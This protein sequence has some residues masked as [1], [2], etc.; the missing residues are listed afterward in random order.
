[1][2]K[3][4]KLVVCMA[5]GLS[6]STSAMADLIDAKGT[7]EMSIKKNGDLVNARRLAR[8]SSE[9]DAILQALRL[10]MS[11]DGDN[12]SVQNA[13]G[14]LSK[15][16]TDN[17]KT[18]FTTEGDVLTAKTSLSVDSAQLYDLARSIKGLVS[19]TAMASSKIIFL[20][21]EYYGISTNIQPGQP[22]ETEISYSHDKSSASSESSAASSSSSSKNSEAVAA[23]A[24]SSMAAS[25]DSSVAGRARSSSA[26]T[27]NASVAAR[28]GD[29]SLSAASNSSAA[30]S[31][32]VSASASRKS[33][34]A[35]A[36]NSNFAAASSSSKAE[37]NSSS[38]AS[39]SNQKDIVNYSMKQKFPDTNNAK[40]S[41]DAAAL[42]T[43][44]LEQII[45]PYGLAYTPERDFRRDLKG[46]KLLISDIE[47]QRKFIEYTEK[48]SKQPF[49]AKYI[50]YG[51]S[52]MSAEG[53]TS[54]GDTVCSGM[55]KLQSFNVDS[56]EALISGTLGKRAQGSS[57]QECRTNLATAL[58][59]ELASTVG[60]TAAKEVQL[61][62]TQG[63]SFYV[64]LYSDKKIS[65]A[66]R[67]EF[68]KKLEAM[69]KIEEGNST[70]TSRAWVIQAASGFRTKLEDIVDDL[71][72]AN[73]EA[74][75][76]KMI[77]K[78]NRVVVCLEGNCPKDF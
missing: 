20:I 11:I 59:T 43:A 71:S 3:L 56:G 47:K 44:R 14:D 58:A 35:A 49:S 33:S 4:K 12:P 52:V 66:I 1:M 60:N 57:D 74:K 73:A 22:L 16:L 23:K 17:L 9:R 36:S 34:V 13:L 38:S 65:S 54:S 8:I 67:R 63:Q 69:G 31:S 64:T 55:L 70:D 53:K 29:S 19:T 5:L 10:R 26:M 42:I 7:V 68:T 24:S 50:V 40:P 51:T 48:A 30:G 76:A 18:T 15:Q 25:E 46:N 32:D 27:N 78:G 6:V 61:A 77:A 72:S 62:A 37:A 21:D 45:K 2:F 75:D 28:Q 39:A 41:D